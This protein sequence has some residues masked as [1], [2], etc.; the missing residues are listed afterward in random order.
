VTRP[1]IGQHE[2]GQIAGQHTD[3]PR[4]PCRAKHSGSVS[5]VV[6]SVGA[7]FWWASW[8]E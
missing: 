3:Q 7:A 8:R 2:V 4:M 1:R 6:Y 5:H